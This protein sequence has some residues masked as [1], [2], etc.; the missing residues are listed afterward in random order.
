MAGGLCHWRGY[1]Q[2][3]GQGSG[4]NALLVF[5]GY[6][7]LALLVA[8]CIAAVIVGNRDDDWPE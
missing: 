1:Q 8:L 6:T 2:G 5:F 7:V 3:K 4:M